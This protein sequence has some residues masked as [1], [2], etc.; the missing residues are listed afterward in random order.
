MVLWDLLE[1]L[2]ELVSQDPLDFL[3]H[4]EQREIWEDLEKREVLVFKDLVEN[5]ASQEFLVSLVKWVH[6][7]KMEVMER[8][9]AQ[10]PLEHQ[11]PQ[12]SRDQEDKLD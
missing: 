10:D 9:V 6:Q 11:D 7:E 3:E 12:V 2:E 4:L 1:N 5:L 8:R